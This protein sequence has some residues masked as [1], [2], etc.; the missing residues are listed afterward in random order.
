MMFSVWMLA[1]AASH[2]KRGGGS[3]K[4]VSSEERDRAEIGGQAE[5]SPP[6]RARGFFVRASIM[7]TM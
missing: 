3:D 1:E 5:I 4:E 7:P 6:R 2:R